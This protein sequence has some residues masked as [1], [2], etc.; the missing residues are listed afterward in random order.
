MPSYAERS[1]DTI[2]AISTPQGEGGIGIVRLSGRRAVDIA[3]LLFRSGKHGGALRE[4]NGLDSHR[5]RHGYVIDPQTSEIIDETM[6]A[7]MLA[8]H[9]YTRED[10]VEINCHGGRLAQQ[11]ILR[12]VL[13]AGARLAEPGEF[14]L[15]A[16]LNGRLDLA[17]AESVAE[18]IAAKSDAA[19]RSAVSVLDGQLSRRLAVIREHLLG[20]LVIL[21]ASVDFPE[22]DLE[23]AEQP[24]LLS[25]AGEAEAML[26]DLVKQFDRG[27]LLRDG[28]RSVILGRPNVGKSSLLNALLLS[29][30]AIVHPSPGTTRDVIEECINVEGIPLKLIDTAGIR[31]ASS[32]VEQIGI[33]R[34]RAAL[35]SAELVLLVF[36][37][38][39]PLTDDDRE[40]LGQ[41]A[42]PS[43]SAS[44]GR[45]V[46]IVLNKSDLPS[47]IDI[48]E[49]QRI[50]PDSLYIQI[51]ALYQERID[52]LCEAIY[53]QASGAD[54]NVFESVLV[55]RERHRAS[56]DA[57]LNSLQH[58]KTSMVTSL[59]GEFA[60]VDLQAALQHLGEIT[61]D[62]CRDDV[63]VRIF[64]EFCIGK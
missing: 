6:L 17:Q 14:T 51:S 41:V 15:R 28:M 36:D 38:S 1:D 26:Q 37:A 45:H 5:L 8:P 33:D 35:E 54:G 64:A 4:L 23:L 49:V 47:K 61:G 16:F 12:A 46:I 25:H 18:V 13:N 44:S 11:R 7:A 32:G 9:S 62:T 34:S 20:I 27:R 59:S 43:A 42:Q 55:T 53:E 30:R 2:A 52:E 60:A 19:L 58:A 29:D 56:L 39:E 10:V 50:F 31:Q 22:E 63:L 40:L 3:R 24:E 48:S 57:A 21:E